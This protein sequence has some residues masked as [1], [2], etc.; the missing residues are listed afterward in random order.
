MSRQHHLVQLNVARLLAPLDS[1][2]IVDFVAALDPINA[3]A[4]AASGFVW[5]LRVRHPTRLRFGRGSTLRVSRLDVAM[6][7]VGPA[8]SGSR[9]T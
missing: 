1:L 2:E 9:R 3:M 6:T 5:R 4:D 8:G 7:I